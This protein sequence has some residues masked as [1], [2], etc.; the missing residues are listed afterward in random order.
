MLFAFLKGFFTTAA[1]ITAIGAQNIFVLKQGLMKSHVFIVILLCWLIDVMLISIGVNGV[2][3]LIM[4]IPHLLDITKYGGAVFLF[5]YGFMALLSAYKCEMSM[6]AN[7]LKEKSLSSIIVTLLAV[8]F[9]NP[10]TYLD[11]M[12]L[13]GSVGAHFQGID[14]VFFII[15]AI[16]ASLFWFIILCYGA[17]YL[18]PYF[19]KPNVWR[20]FNI[21]VGITM[22]SIATSLIL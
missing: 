16:N 3:K 13:I 12:I 8:S 21:F 17:R 20:I 10:H 2:G 19:Q 14:R 18:A 4:T 1:L 22:W 6:D 7:D 5:C 9:L 11:T 15:G